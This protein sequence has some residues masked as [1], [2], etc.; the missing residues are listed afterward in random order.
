MPSSIRF[1]EF[2]FALIARIP[3][4]KKKGVI[5][6]LHSIKK[7]DWTYSINRRNLESFLKKL[8]QIG[9]VVSLDEFIWNENKHGLFTLTFDD[10]Y[11]DVFTNAYPVLSK[12]GITACVFVSGIPNKNGD[13]NYLDGRERLNLKQIKKL[14]KEGWIIGY[15]SKTHLD[16]R[17]LD[18]NVLYEE[19]VRGKKRLEERLGFDIKYFAYPYGLYNKKVMNIVSI[20][21]YENA[22]TVSGGGFKNRKLPYK[23][24]RV[25]IDRF[26]KKEDLE[27]ITSYKGLFFNELLTKFLNI[28]NSL[29]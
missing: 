29:I 25:L 1:R 14:R 21:G 11:E 17:S 19:I 20:A 27:I 5:F 28:K 13:F 4:V 18:D 10:G 24:D 22:F 9:K 7:S 16:L 3:V 6:C 8:L 15:H 12:Y 23:I 26:I 2:I